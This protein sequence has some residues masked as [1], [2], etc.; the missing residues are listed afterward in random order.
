MDKL[1]EATTVQCK[2]A[3]AGKC[4]NELKSCPHFLPHWHKD[5]CDIVVPDVGNCNGA[6]CL[7]AA[8][9]GVK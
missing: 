3:I 6:V 1:S 9:R 2:T 5:N 7:S 4:K 8:Q